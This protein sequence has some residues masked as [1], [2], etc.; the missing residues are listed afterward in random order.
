MWGKNQAYQNRSEVAKEMVTWLDDPDLARI[1]QVVQTWPDD[2]WQ[3]A[4]EVVIIQQVAPYLYV[5]LHQTALFNAFA[6]EFQTLLKREY[7]HNALRVARIQQD[8][9]NILTATTTAGL[10]TMPLKGAILGPHYY[11]TPAL[12]PMADLDLLIHPEDC[13]KPKEFW[14]IWVMS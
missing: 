4:G 12:R 11:S 13:P 8:W 14:K 7:E 10:E 9:R 5:H 3:A 6:P 1:E 2:L